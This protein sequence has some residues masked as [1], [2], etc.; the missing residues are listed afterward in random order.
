VLSSR[1]RSRSLCFVRRY[2]RARS[3]YQVIEETTLQVE[4]LLLLV[5]S[6]WS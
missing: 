2:N 4:H 3:A 6:A 5:G 1:W